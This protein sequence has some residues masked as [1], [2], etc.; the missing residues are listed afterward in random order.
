MTVENINA[1]IS[2]C[3]KCELRETCSQVVVG[4]GAIPADIMFVGEAL[5]T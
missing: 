3:T 5:P 1:E 2:A 4:D